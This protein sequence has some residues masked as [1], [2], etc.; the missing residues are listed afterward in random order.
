MVKKQ[1]LKMYIEGYKD[2]GF[3]VVRYSIR[4]GKEVR[5]VLYFSKSYDRCED[6]IE[7]RKLEHEG[8]LQSQIE[9]RK[10]WAEKESARRKAETKR[11]KAEEHRRYMAAECYEKDILASYHE[12]RE[13][14]ER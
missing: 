12:W 13:N 2:S 5:T 1:L 6:Y 11:R 4:C 8:A 10:R 3:E 14:I 7:Y 9:N